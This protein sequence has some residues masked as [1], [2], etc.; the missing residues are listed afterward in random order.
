M[1]AA[2]ASEFHDAGAV[3]ERVLPTD[4]PWAEL[5]IWMQECSARNTELGGNEEAFISLIVM[6]LFQVSLPIR[7]G[8]QK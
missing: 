3:I 4:A 8:G 7:L 1:T 5:S 2:E 6:W